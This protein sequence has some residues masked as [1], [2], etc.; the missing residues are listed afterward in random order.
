M[1]GTS[2]G[3]I[4]LDLGVNYSSFSNQLKK[5]APKSEKMVGLAFG[6]LGT[7]AAA[8]FSAKALLGFGKQ[9][10]GIASDLEEVQN[11][12]DVTFKDMAKTINEFADGAIF[13]LGLSE[14]SAK[15]YASTMGAMLKSSGLTGKAVTDMSIEM[16]KLAADM[17]SF[18]NLDTDT[19]FNK[20]RAGLSGETEPLKQ[21]GINLSVANL[22][23]YAFSQGIEKSYQKMS[24]AEQV[25]LRYNYLLSVS[26]DAQGDFIRNQDSWANQT[27]ILS[28][29]WKQLIGMIGKGL[30]E[31]LL[32]VVKFLNKI[33][34]MLVAIVQKVGQ[35]YARI[36]GKQLVE[37][38]E[39]ISIS[40]GDA[41]EAQLDLGDSIKD[42]AK[43]AKKAL[44]P[45]DELNVLM[46][47]MG[48]GGDS[49]GFN[50]DFGS[51]IIESKSTFTEAM[52]EMEED[53]D[54][55]FIAFTDKWNRA[56][57]TMMVPIQVPAPVFADIPQPIYQ[58]EWGLTPPLIPAPVIP[59]IDY[60]QYQISMESIKVYTQEKLR[61][62]KN[63]FATN[64]GTITAG[65]STFLEGLRLKYQE[66][67]NQLN[68][69]AGL[70]LTTFGLL[71]ANKYSETFG[72]IE[73]LSSKHFLNMGSIL[74]TYMLGAETNL[75]THLLN[76][77]TNWGIH[78]LNV[79]TIAA[80]IGLAYS[81]NM[82]DA[83]MRVLNNQMLTSI[84]LQGNL[85]IMGA[86]IGE[87][88][89]EISKSLVLNFNSSFSTITENFATFANSFRENMRVFGEGLLEISIEIAKGLVDNYVNGFMTIYQNFISLMG[90]LGEKVSGHFSE[91]KGFYTKA[92]I[93]VAGAAI[94]GGIAL[95]APA[96]IPFV[97][98]A[99][100]ALGGI[101]ATIPALANGG[102]TNG[103]TL[104]MVGDNPGGKEVISPLDDLTDIITTAVV[105]A[106]AT[107]LEL[108]G[109]GSFG[110][111]NSEGK[112][113]VLNIDGKKLIRMLLPILDDELQ[114]MGYATIYRTT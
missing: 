17:A 99:G 81:S 104:A 97:A 41:E 76:M 16:T 107:L 43:Q 90:A 88:A 49:T 68:L 52:K 110:G 112:E 53:A 21:L 91:N 60:T 42:A 64:W 12:V 100:A 87:I 106:I 29:Q 33:L 109:G 70:L 83:F 27:R 92:G 40:A 9:A 36:T 51:E 15:K 10:I 19:A 8:A 18:Y 6:K 35:I 25:M 44:A 63:N 98:K 62:L 108:Q 7:V 105:N 102:I 96:A 113:I 47:D 37:S 22:E 57:Q 75:A 78:R 2:I 24:Q 26:K 4:F 39:S 95:L 67:L 20:I 58:P 46:T 80:A 79:E 66:K 5:L 77:E 93:V 111:R 73:G 74:S 101:A 85:N 94:A 38:N 103:P 65:A 32:P 86:N 114:R 30:I 50:I 3:Q 61:E 45:F 71:A 48:K 1:S 54:K 23:A 11:V 82:T 13:S 84:A 31:V 14:L 59:P 72:N 56:K 55:W 89:A 34:S 69:E 28:E